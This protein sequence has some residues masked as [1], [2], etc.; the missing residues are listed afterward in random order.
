VGAVGKVRRRRCKDAH[1][2]HPLLRQEKER[3]GR[4]L[5]PALV[6]VGGAAPDIGGEAIHLTVLIIINLPN[7][8]VLFLG[9]DFIIRL[10]VLMVPHVPPAPRCERRGE[11]VVR[12][13]LDAIKE[14]DVPEGT[15]ESAV[16]PH[17]FH[18][19]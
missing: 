18:L 4:E 15:E 13:A 7:V 5:G 16:A 11:R 17:R 9:G 14:R 1:R 8:K 12:N 2:R 6:E 10:Q 3:K 19:G